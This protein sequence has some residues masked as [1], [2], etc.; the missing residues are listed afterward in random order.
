LIA[1]E[2]GF[3]AQAVSPKGA[4][5]LMQLMPATAQR[6]GVAADKRATIEKKLFDPR[7]NIAAGSRYLRDLIEMFPG[8]LELALAAYNAG[9]GAVQRA[10]NR[11]PN[12][13][14]TQ[15]YVKTVLQ[16]YAYLKP[17]AGAGGGGRVPGRVRMELAPPKGGALGRG[18]LPPDSPAVA[19][20]MPEATADS[21]PGAQP[22]RIEPLLP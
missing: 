5:G 21:L 17:A 4:L 9:E 15:D 1:T 18:N 12:Y 13:R 3:D 2:S 20:A 19:P 22:L 14:E 10:G 16:L 6:Y 8:E 11:I 7:I